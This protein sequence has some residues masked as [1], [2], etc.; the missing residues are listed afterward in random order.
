[1]KLNYYNI[2]EIVA[3]AFTLEAMRIKEQK[4][5]AVAGLK[6]QE[7]VKKPFHN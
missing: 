3:V 5:G 6:E 4:S 7:S 1:M 2:L